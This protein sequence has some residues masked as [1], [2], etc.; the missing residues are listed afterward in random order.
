MNR[1]SKISALL[2][3][4]ILTACSG[5]ATLTLSGVGGT[6]AD[7]TGLSI[8]T[9]TLPPRLSRGQRFTA[10]VVIRNFGKALV[11]KVLPV[12]ELTPSG[13]A[14]AHL[15][16]AASASDI[17]PGAS[18]T[19]AFS[20]IENGAAVG[21]LQA[22]IRPRAGDA[23]AFAFRTREVVENPA[24]LSLVSVNLPDTVVQSRGY[25]LSVT[26]TN[27]GDAAA[28]QVVPRA[29]QLTGSVQAMV[30]SA[31][32]PVTLAGHSSQTFGWPYQATG[33]GT[34]ALSFKAQ[35]TG[36][37]GNSG[38]TL[39]PAPANSNAS[40][41][42]FPTDCSLA[43]PCFG[44]G[45]A[46]L[47]KDR[48]DLPTGSD[49]LR[50]KPYSMLP[51]EY[52]RVLGA[53]PASLQQQAATFN[54]PPARWNIEPALAAVS[55][56]QAFES[57]FEGCLTFT[58]SASTYGANP[59]PATAATVCQALSE[60]FWS[61]SPTSGELQS[62]SAFA[63]GSSNNDANPRRRWAYTCASVLASAGFLTH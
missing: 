39:E 14:A 30:A 21:T 38:A 27:D 6:P 7:A 16:T 5:R 41:V 10:T 61:R 33:P 22:L 11:S 12:L 62:C 51:S 28:V 45:G 1:L 59:T 17:A 53:T 23:D 36:Q 13:G 58:S 32:P 50:V 19:F 52:R 25:T 8:T 18:T 42:T 54:A 15:V 9:A 56:Y 35:V 29:V 40:A 63:T 46:Q 47:Q 4:M 44:F 37:D 20:L 3:A 57:A 31:Q 43:S 48:L 2:P 26:V 24:H 60:G 55:L 49:H 34:A